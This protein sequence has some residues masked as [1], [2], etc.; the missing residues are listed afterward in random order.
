MIVYEWSGLKRV[1]SGG[2]TGSDQAGLQAAKDC[3]IETGGWA[4][5]KWQTYIGPRKDFLKSF[6]LKEHSSGY[7]DR[8]WANVRDSDGTIRLASNFSSSGERCTLNAIN[9]FKKPYLDIELI[10]TPFR[11][12]HTDS[13]IKFIIDN[14]IETLNIAGNSDKY[15]N[16]GFGF[17]YHAAYTILLDAFLKL[18]N[19]PKRS[20]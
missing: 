12:N 8:T 20:I 6:N 11:V 13:I 18:K 15:P 10:D 17:H 16:N 2:Q 19:E 5:N 1:I 4:P 14:Q 3:Q 9:K 7:K